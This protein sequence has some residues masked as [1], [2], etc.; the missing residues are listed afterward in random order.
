MLFVCPLCAD[1]R[2]DL[3]Y[4]AAHFEVCAAA[5]F[6]PSLAARR[7]RVL[8]FPR[9]CEDMDRIILRAVGDDCRTYARMSRVSRAWHRAVV[10]VALPA[11][12]GRGLDS[13]MRFARNGSVYNPYPPRALRFRHQ[14]AMRPHPPPLQA[15]AELL[16]D[17]AAP[18]LRVTF[19]FF[20]SPNA[21]PDAMIEGDSVHWHLEVPAAQ[22][23]VQW[24]FD[25]IRAR[26]PWVLSPWH[27]TTL[28]TPYGSI[29]Q[30]FAELSLKL[31]AVDAKIY[32]TGYDRW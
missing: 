18:T 28:Q 3:P 16:A 11:V 21:P 27:Y 5:S 15:C 1:A 23:T 9:S 24:L 31:F 19:P 20:W 13:L 17:V 12:V 25:A 22:A 14:L 29:S 8:L 2:D 10:N 30:A 7:T 26:M 32:V 6:L 4:D